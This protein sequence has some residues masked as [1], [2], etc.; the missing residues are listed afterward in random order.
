[1]YL[2]DD[3]N[4]KQLLQQRNLE[5]HNHNLANKIIA[6]ADSIKHQRINS[7]TFSMPTLVLVLFLGFLIG[8]NVNNANLIAID[9]DIEIFLYYEGEV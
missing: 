6:K 2:D 4:L 8:S 5:E 9:D 3:I 1:M 7:K